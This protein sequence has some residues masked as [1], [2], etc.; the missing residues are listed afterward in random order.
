MEYIGIF[1]EEYEFGGCVSGIDKINDKWIMTGIYGITN[2]MEILFKDTRL[3]L[4]HMEDGNIC[5]KNFYNG[6]DENNY[7]YLKGKFVWVKYT[8]PCIFAIRD[9]FEGLIFNILT[10]KI[11]EITKK[12]KKACIFKHLKYYV[13]ESDDIFI[14]FREGN[15]W[16]FV[17]K[18]S[19]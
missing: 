18:A 4:S 14:Q 6:L 7:N 10:K 16:T 11:F 13:D 5:I 15:D 9:N 12:I 17:G 3:Y 2:Q 1:Q 8:Y 19:I